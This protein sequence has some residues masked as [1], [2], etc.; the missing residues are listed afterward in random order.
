M[1]QQDNKLWNDA[2]NRNNRARQD[3]NGRTF[4]KMFLFVVLPL[5]LI[6]I[7]LIIS[8]HQATVAREKK[9]QEEQLSFCLAQANNDYWASQEDKEVAS[10]D[11]DLNLYLAKRQKSGIEAKIECHKEYDSNNQATVKSLQAEKSDIEAQI[12]YYESAAR[13]NTQ[14]SQRQSTYCY[15]AGIGSSAFTHCY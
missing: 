7:P 12:D 2:P 8:D 6:F 15:T 14:N 3:P 9:K 11:P 1:Q 10:N 13:S 4:L 5:S